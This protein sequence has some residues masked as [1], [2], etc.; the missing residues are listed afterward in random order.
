M[1]RNA[2]PS[3]QRDMSAPY[4]IMVYDPDL[5]TVGHVSTLKGSMA[6]V[7]STCTWN[8]F[9]A[10]C[11]KNHIQTRAKRSRM[12]QYFKQERAKVKYCEADEAGEIPDCDPATAKVMDQITAEMLDALDKCQDRTQCTCNRGSPEH[13]INE[14]ECSTVSGDTLCD[15]FLRVLDE[16]LYPLI[17]D[18]LD[19][20]SPDNSDLQLLRLCLADPLVIADTEY[21]ER[22][23]PTKMQG[24]NPLKFDYGV[25]SRTTLSQCRLYARTMKTRLVATRKLLGI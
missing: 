18:Q 9:L 22:E 4:S 3:V 16:D 10:L 8:Q 11:N 17:M 7:P 21:V 19:K 15:N 6:Q 1:T 5:P 14:D 20:L 13:P 23:L 2:K 12:W 25:G 24:H